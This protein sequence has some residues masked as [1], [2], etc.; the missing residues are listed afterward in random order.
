MAIPPTVGFAFSVL[1]A[2][3]S[4][5]LAP[6]ER[7]MTRRARKQIQALLADPNH[8]IMLAARGGNLGVMGRRAGNRALARFADLP[9]GQAAV[10]VMTIDPTTG[11]S[12]DGVELIAGGE[13]EQF[14][15]VDG[16]DPNVIG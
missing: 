13:F 16:A 7:V 10:V 14:G 5:D 8:P 15:V 11:F 1:R 4:G 3:Q 6:I 9:S 12:L 2:L